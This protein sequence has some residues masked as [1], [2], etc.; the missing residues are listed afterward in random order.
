[1]K[2]RDMRAKIMAA[3]LALVAGSVI[4]ASEHPT[5]GMRQGA[6]HVDKIKTAKVEKTTEGKQVCP[7]D[8]GFLCIGKKGGHYCVQPNGDKKYKA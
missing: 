7:C 5:A 6:Y 2:G 4:A 1:M 3:L 8:K